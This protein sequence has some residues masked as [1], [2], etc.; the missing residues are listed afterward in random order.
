MRERVLGCIGVVWGG[1][2]LLY[3]FLHYSAQ[4]DGFDALVQVF[5][6]VSGLLVL[7]VGIASAVAPIRSDSARKSKAKPKRAAT[8]PPNKQLQRTGHE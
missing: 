2:I 4:R 1:A 5:N 3:A 8:S 7:L 6:F